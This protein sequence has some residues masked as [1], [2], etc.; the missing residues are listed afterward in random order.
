[1]L[2]LCLLFLFLRTHMGPFLRFGYLAHWP[3]NFAFSV[4]NAF[5]F[6]YVTFSIFV[7]YPL[8]MLETVCFPQ[9]VSICIPAQGPALSIICTVSYMLTMLP[10]QLN[11]AQFSFPQ[12]GSV[13]KAPIDTTVSARGGIFL[14]LAT[15]P[16]LVRFWREWLS[17]STF[18]F[19][20]IEMG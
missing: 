12:L 7:V 20:S 9:S 2:R 14:H 11:R 18:Q 1:M 5:I 3:R 19:C 16:C 6:R 4:F 8:S 15:P 13:C 17:F 10:G